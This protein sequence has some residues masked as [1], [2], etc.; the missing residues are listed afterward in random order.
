MALHQTGR[1]CSVV[2]L[3][4]VS[5]A[6]CVKQN[7]TCNKKDSF[8]LWKVKREGKHPL[9]Q[10][11][12][13]SNPTILCSNSEHAPLETG[14]PYVS[15]AFI[16]F[17]KSLVKEDNTQSSWSQHSSSSP[18]FQTILTPWT[19]ACFG[20]HHWESVLPRPPKNLQGVWAVCFG[21]EP[22]HTC[23]LTLRGTL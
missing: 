9:L 7:V 18:S 2:S 16:G 22:L 15:G 21:A 19:C 23:L 5:Q 6:L 13:F 17:L 10:Q 8:G 4:Y 12:G 20:L 11:W 1:K 14:C 3:Q